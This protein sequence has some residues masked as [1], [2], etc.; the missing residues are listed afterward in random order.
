MTSSAE[1]ALVLPSYGSGGAERVVLN[2][3]GGLRARG[4]DV[5]LVVLD[6]RG[7]LRRAVPDGVRTV[8]LRV[9]RARWAVP[10]LVRE[11]RGRPADLVIGSQTHVNVLLGLLRP[12]LPGR[13]RLVL[14]EPNLR[15]VAER[16]PR[17]ERRVGRSLG[18]ADL[19]VASSEAM[20][21]HLRTTVGGR[22]AIHV[23]A[24]P[25]DVAHLRALAAGG[26]PI[27]RPGGLVSVGS[28]TEQK[29]H[30]D[31]IDALATAGRGASPGTPLTILGDG[32]L[33]AAL[34]DR[35]RRLGL[36]DR[37]HLAGRVDDPATLAA[38]VAAAGLLVHPAR[39][40]GMPNAVLEALALGTPVL[41]T[42]DLSVLTEL[43]AEV[44]PEGLRRVPRAELGARIAEDVRPAWEGP[45][46]RPSL[47]PERFGVDAVVTALLEALDGIGRDRGA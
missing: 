32:P 16:D 43:A 12:M 4:W 21:D 25:V 15:P 47:I 11:L 42:T 17:R 8:E 33:R 10:A 31:L 28:L 34:E 38:T 1:A 45:N 26:T 36:T 40:E 44:G 20:R 35:V 3:A 30:A 13:T 23:L 37:V 9:R 6:P 14:R 24:N 46:P 41:A 19:V 5:R 18:R 39:F 29:A 27:G 7:P 2:L 22:A